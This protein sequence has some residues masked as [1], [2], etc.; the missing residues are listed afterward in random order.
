MYRSP[1][2]ERVIKLR[3]L[4]LAFKILTGKPTGKRALGRPGRTWEGSLKIDIKDI[5]IKMR[6]WI[7][8]TQD[9]DYFE[10][11]VDSALHFRVP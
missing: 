4:S 3:K 1:N 8:S 9:S 6:N 2:I 5:I 11:L 10:A 7:E